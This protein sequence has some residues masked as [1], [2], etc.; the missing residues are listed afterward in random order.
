M[1]EAL[2][3][4]EELNSL[5]AER[6]YLLMEVQ[7]ITTARDMVPRGDKATSARMLG[8]INSLQAQIGNMRPKISALREKADGV[9][10]HGM[11][12]EAV[13]AVFGQDAPS[14]CF[15]YMNEQKR[16]KRQ[17]RETMGAG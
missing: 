5:L 9:R 14:K 8:E 17:Q 1:S 13:A 10:R 11:L 16:I 15:A 6:G 3:I 12:M 4:D 2:F 7:R